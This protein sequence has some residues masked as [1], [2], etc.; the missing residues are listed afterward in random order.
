M[1][2]LPVKVLGVPPGKDHVVVSAPTDVFVKLVVK[3]TAQPVAFDT[4]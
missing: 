2:P 4:V 3:G 1:G